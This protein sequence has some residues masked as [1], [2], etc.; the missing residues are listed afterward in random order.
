VFA[1]KAPAPDV[2]I[3]PACRVVTPWHQ[4]LNRLRELA[5]GDARHGSCGVGIGEVVRDALENEPIRA[6]DLGDHLVER[7]EAV[8]QRLWPEAVQSASAICQPA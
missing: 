8:R 7:A 3:S 1:A 4:A 2:W 5:R 6:G